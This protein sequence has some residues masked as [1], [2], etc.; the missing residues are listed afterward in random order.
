[1]STEPKTPDSPLGVTLSGLA[2]GDQQ[3]LADGDKALR[4]IFGTKRTEMAEALSKHCF[5]VLNADETSNDNP[6]CDERGFMLMAVE[7]LE[8]RDAVER[9][10][11][12]QMAATHVATIR[13][14]RWLANSDNITQV[15]AH[16]TGFNKLARTFAIQVEALRKHRNGGN[17]TVT[18]QRVNVGDG[19]Q[20]IVG[21]VQ[22]GGRA[23]DEK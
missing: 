10:L 14:G 7:E 19:G 17:Q 1:M 18:V 6:L 12:V 16:Y 4:G 5:R 23:S 3:M 15:Q 9:M 20:A 21:N 8:P 2:E 13:S 11:A 22:T